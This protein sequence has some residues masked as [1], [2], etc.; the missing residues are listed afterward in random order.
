MLF[1]WRSCCWLSVSL[2]RSSSINAGILPCGRGSSHDRRLPTRLHR[3]RRDAEERSGPANR[4]NRRL[5]GRHIDRNAPALACLLSC[6]QSGI[7]ASCDPV[8]ADRRSLRGAQRFP[9]RRPPR[10][11]RQHQPAGLVAVDRRAGFHRRYRPGAL[12]ESGYRNAEGAFPGPPAGRCRT[13]L[14]AARTGW[15]GGTGL[16]GL[17]MGIALGLVLAIAII[18]VV[19]WPLFR[20]PCTSQAGARRRARE[21]QE[22]KAEIYRQ[23][24]QAEHD[25]EP[26]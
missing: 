13:V 10:T 23:I 17:A 24:R 2:A 14:Q 19:V 25:R 9:E 21:L 15:T 3:K 20:P 26:G 12:A 6:L 22:S 7:G 16:D 11:A 1:T 8:D 18:A 5:Q 4:L